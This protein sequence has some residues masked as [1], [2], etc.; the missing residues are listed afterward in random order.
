LRKELESKIALY[1]NWLQ[2]EKIVTDI[3]TEKEQNDVLFQEQI[4]QITDEK[5][6]QIK[7]LQS[8]LKKRDN[9]KARLAQNTG[10]FFIIHGLF[11]LV[12]IAI[13]ATVLNHNALSLVYKEINVYIIWA[14]A[15]VVSFS[16][17]HF[18]YI[19]DTKKIYKSIAVIPLDLLAANFAK[20][21]LESLQ[22]TQSNWYWVVYSGLSLI[23][24]IQIFW[25]Y[26]SLLN[27]FISPEFREKIKEYFA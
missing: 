17:F 27:T 12:I 21:A 8:V 18:M 4:N 11:M 22:T 24:V 5:D 25:L 23:Y 6:Q 1:E 16:P 3:Q 13:I 14:F 26:G 15:Y 7:N 9:N 19:G 20:P 2:S 10:K